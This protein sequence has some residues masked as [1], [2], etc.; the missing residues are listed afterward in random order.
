MA[1]EKDM[2]KLQ[3][4]IG[5]SFFELIEFS[6]TRRVRGQTIKGI[7]GVNVAKVRE[8]VRMPKI[9][10]LASR[11]KGVAGVFEL[12]GIP[13]PAVSLN[14]ALGD[15]VADVQQSQQIIV[16]EFSQKRAG[17]IVD[18]THRIRRVA[19]DKVLPPSADAGT[20][21]NGMTLIEDNEFLFI[22]DLEKILLNLEFGE[23]FTA[24]NLGP[25]QAADA[26]THAGAPPSF[27]TGRPVAQAAAPQ[28][29]KAPTGPVILLVDDSQFIRNGVKQAMIRAGYRILEAGDGAE[30]L[31]V[32]EKGLAGQGPQVS[33]VVT[34]VEMPRMDG[35]SFTKKVR[36]HDQL[37]EMPIL[38]HTSLSG[39]ANQ[40]AGVSVGAN[41]YVIKNDFRALFELMKEI[42]GAAPDALSA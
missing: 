23:A 28:A 29:P 33:L 21:I 10:T 37:S 42:L 39:K 22:L 15:D 4:E 18:S 36:E 34:D 11:I 9:N 8:V 12:R 19:W 30:A 2:T 1:E 25:M 32:L 40:A 14:M 35:L 3:L 5:G 20:C 26:W 7:Y 6:L 24:R 38:L 27:A 17:F 31:S 16:T 41:G 13:I